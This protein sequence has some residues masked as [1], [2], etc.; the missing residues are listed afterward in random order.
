MISGTAK[1]CPTTAPGTRV[2]AGSNR[3]AK[4][5]LAALLLR[6]AG[7]VPSHICCAPT[8]QAPASRPASSRTIWRTSTTPVDDGI[9][10]SSGV[11]MLRA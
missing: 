5:A 1:P 6:C 8:R 9:Q 4:N 10:S 7:N 2:K 11:S 3:G